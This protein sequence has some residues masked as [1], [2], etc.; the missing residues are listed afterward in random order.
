MVG[1]VL[2]D[3]AN[4]IVASGYNG[5]PRGLPHCMEVGCILDSDGHCIRSIHAEENAILQCAIHGISTE[6][7]TLYSTHRP[8]TRCTMRLFQAGIRTVFY[9]TEYQGQTSIPGMRIE[10]VEK[11]K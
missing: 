6:G 8:C 4:R 10:K 5:S 1:A 11:S 3:D 2:V 9:L 7:L